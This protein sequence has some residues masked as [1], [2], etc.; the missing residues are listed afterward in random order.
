MLISEKLSPKLALDLFK[1][2]VMPICL[3]GSEIWG[4][5]HNIKKFFKRCDILPLEKVVLHFAKFV[6]G[7]H[8][9]SSNAGVRYVENWDC[10]QFILMF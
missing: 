3:Y 8:K 9:K 4:I 5:T 1:K 7:V 2:V 10:T 6:L